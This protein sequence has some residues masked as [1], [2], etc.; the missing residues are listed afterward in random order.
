MT[1]HNIKM[2][3]AKAAYTG[4]AGTRTIAAVSDYITQDM[5]DSMTGAQIGAVMSA[6]YAAYNAGRASTGA[7]VED[8]C[9]WVAGK[10]IPLAAID[11]LKIER[12]QSHELISARGAQLYGSALY[13]AS[14]QPLD[15][16]ATHRARFNNGEGA[17][18]LRHKSLI[19]YTMDYEE[20]C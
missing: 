3:R 11:A 2:R 12:T 6:V 18:Y 7:S 10:L 20:R 5:M 13:D 14:G 8:D 19:T 4:F 9:V 15:S 17:Y 1:N 16:N